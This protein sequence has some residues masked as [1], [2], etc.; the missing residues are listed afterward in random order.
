M[1]S[2]NYETLRAER[3]V[4]NKQYNICLKAKLKDMKQ[5]PTKYNFKPPAKNRKFV[6]INDINHSLM[7]WQYYLANVNREFLKSVLTSLTV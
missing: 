2:L 4:K 5:N 7:V 6:V 3:I 1:N